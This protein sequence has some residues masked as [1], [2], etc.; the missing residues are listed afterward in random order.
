MTGEF[1]LKHREKKAAKR[2][3]EGAGA[4]LQS[5]VGKPDNREGLPQTFV[6]EPGNREGL[7]LIVLEEPLLV[8]Y[9]R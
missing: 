5:A 3:E 4:E 1:L 7:Q 2:G 9:G 8:T 6:E